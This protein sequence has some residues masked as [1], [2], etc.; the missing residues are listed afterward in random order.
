MIPQSL[1]YESIA[2][3]NYATGPYLIYI[4]YYFFQKVVPCIISPYNYSNL[5]SIFYMPHFRLL[6]NNFSIVENYDANLQTIFVI[7]KFFVIFFHFFL[8]INQSP[9]NWTYATHLI[10][11]MNKNFNYQITMQIYNLFFIYANFQ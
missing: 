11:L 7:C 9:L 1:D 2:L 3:T 4:K 10:L 6:H 5:C 8:I